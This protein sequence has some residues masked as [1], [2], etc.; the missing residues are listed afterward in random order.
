ME[1][2]VNFNQACYQELRRRHENLFPFSQNLMALYFLIQAELP[3]RDR[4]RLAQHFVL[5]GINVQDWTVEILKGA[6][7][8]L[9]VSTIGSLFRTQHFDLLIKL[10]VDS[11]TSWSMETMMEK[12]VFG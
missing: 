2:N 1:D 4:E 10:V 8:E 3:E 11:I 12:K 5:R 7:R 9:F 6:F